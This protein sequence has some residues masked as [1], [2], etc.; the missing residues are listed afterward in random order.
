MSETRIYIVSQDA[1]GRLRLRDGRRFI[2]E[3]LLL[4]L[5]KVARTGTKEPTP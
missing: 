4:Q 3:A 1:R 5:R 2:R